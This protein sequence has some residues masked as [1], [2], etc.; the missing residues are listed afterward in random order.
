MGRQKAAKEEKGGG[1]VAKP[2]FWWQSLRRLVFL[3]LLAAVF[4]TGV[5]AG[6]GEGYG[7]AG[8]EQWAAPRGEEGRPASQEWFI[9]AG[10]KVAGF[11]GEIKEA[12]VRPFI[13]LHL[14]IQSRPLARLRPFPQLRLPL[15]LDPPVWLRLPARVRLPEWWQPSEWLRLLA[16]LRFSTKLHLPALSRPVMESPAPARQANPPAQPGFP[17]KKSVFFPVL[18]WEKQEF[19]PDRV[20]FTLPEKAGV[21]AA[22]GGFVA[23]LLPVKGGWRVRLEHGGWSSVYYPLAGLT[24]ARSGRVRAGEKLGYCAAGETGE[25]KLFWE[26]WHGGAAVS[27]RRL[28]SHRP[29]QETGK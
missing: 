15:R 17:G 21:Y 5:L 6:A 18:S 9:D 4:F 25:T 7:P 12:L 2:A 29:A 16:R 8:K 27:P 22:A 14:F 28:L 10:K 13:R 19:F 23:E 1:I 26:V 24:I 20:G 11:A 3:L